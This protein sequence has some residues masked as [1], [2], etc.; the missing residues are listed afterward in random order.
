[1]KKIMMMAVAAFMA[2]CSAYAQFEKGKQRVYA[3]CR[4]QI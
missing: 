2:T 4:L 1:M 3:D